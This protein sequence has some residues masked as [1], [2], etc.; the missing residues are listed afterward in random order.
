M[1]I[2]GEII[3]RERCCV[4][5]HWVSRRASK[6]FLGS[7]YRRDDNHCDSHFKSPTGIQVGFCDCVGQFFRHTKP[8]SDFLSI[9][10]KN[11]HLCITTHFFSVFLHFSSQVAQAEAL[12]T[13]C[14][15]TSTSM[16]HPIVVL[17]A[18]GKMTRSTTTQKWVWIEISWLV[19]M[20]NMSSWG[21]RVVQEGERLSTNH[22]LVVWSPIMTH[23][24]GGSIPNPCSQRINESLGKVLNPKLLRMVWSLVC[25]CMWSVVGGQ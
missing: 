5:P 11:L 19:V 14:F 13:T 16:F 1:K 25:E 15:N 20:V 17:I 18:P 9:L 4:V 23:L 10:R 6:P 12:E 24:I 3:S 2:R 21:S 22:G 8:F 7:L